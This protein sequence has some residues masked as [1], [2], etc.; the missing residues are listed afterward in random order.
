ML[1]TEISIDGRRIGRGQQPYVIAEA[2]SNHNQSLDTARRLIDV[3]ADSGCDAVKFQ[4]FEAGELYP[5]G[6]EHY[7][8]FK[9]IELSP[10]WLQP[11]QRH[12]RG[13]GICFFASVF[14]RQSID[15][16]AALDTPAFK[17]ASSDTTKLDLLAY[18][19]S[20][21]K[22]LIISTGMC[23][24]VDVM[25][26]VA[27]CTRNGNSDIALL[28]CAALYPTPPKDANLAAMD[29]MRG[30]FK[31]PVGYSDHVLGTTIA[32]AAAA[33]GAAVIEKHF[34]LDRNSSGPDHFY[35]LEP[36]ELADM[37]RQIRDVYAAIGD[38]SKELHPEERR[39]GRRDGLH[40][41]KAIGAGETFSEDNVVV[42]RPATGIRAR[43]LGWVLNRPAARVIGAGDPIQWDDVLP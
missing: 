30:L 22:P 5:P 18:I 36:N 26:A 14:D 32:V 8:L 2:G 7:E 23:D 40:A 3:A 13:R 11:I 38:G 39:V 21:K 19:A 41:L 34:T 29:T 37:V 16:M 15:R 1:A 33:R 4:L 24:L 25:E 27:C 31:C 35:A 42:R 9:S 43:H 10:D 6:H 20:K 17:V 28:Q 12:A